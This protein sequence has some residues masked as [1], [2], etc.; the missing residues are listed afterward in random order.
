MGAVTV[1]TQSASLLLWPSQHIGIILRH[2][3]VN[4][5]A[6]S[7]VRILVKGLHLGSSLSP[8]PPAHLHLLSS[9]RQLASQHAPPV[10]P[11][12]ASSLFATFPLISPAPRHSTDFSPATP[13]APASYSSGAVSSS[14]LSAYPTYSVLSPLSLNVAASTAGQS[15]ATVHAATAA[16]AAAAAAAGAPQLS[17]P[18]A[19]AGLVGSTASPRGCAGPA[20]DADVGTVAATPANISTVGL[21]EGLS[22]GV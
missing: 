18:P 1:Q 15:L 7:S 22:K 8:R 11:P 12:S 17:V 5:R 2:S 9:E 3:H 4:L 13:G 16:A 14:S 6:R 10:L 20:Q 21:A 19:S